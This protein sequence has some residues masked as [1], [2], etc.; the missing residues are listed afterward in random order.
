MVLEEYFGSLAK[1]TLGI[2]TAVTM[3]LAEEVIKD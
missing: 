1:E 2:P 3:Q